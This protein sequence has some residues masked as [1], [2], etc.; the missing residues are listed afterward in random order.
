[1]HFKHDCR[2]ITPSHRRTNRTKQRLNRNTTLEALRQNPDVPVLIIGAG[3]N[4]IGVLRDLAL[5]GV[6]ALLI[7]KSDF[8]AG[9]SAASGRVAHG[10]LRYLENGEFRLVREALHERNRLLINAPHCVVP[11]PI[12]M[13]AYSWTKG[14]LHAARQFLHLKSRPGDRGAAILKLGMTLY[15]VYSGK[16]TL[17]AHRFINRKASL[18]NRPSMNPAITCTALYYDALILYPERLCLE[19]IFDAAESHPNAHALN[20]VSAVGIEGKSVLLRDEL[21]GEKFPIKPQVVVNATGAWID[22]TNRTMQVESAFIGGTKG[23]HLIVDHPELHRL[24]QG[25]MLFY[26]NNDARICIFYPLGHRVLIGTTDI[27][28]NDPDSVVCAEDE[29]EYLLQ[30]IC[31]VFP[32]IRLD[33]SHIVYTFSG[34][35]PLPKSSALTAGQ[36]S[37]DH[38]D[39]IIESGKGLPFRI[40]NLVGGKWTTYR[41]FAEQVTD[42]L[43]SELGEKRKADTRALRIGGGREFPTTDEQRRVWIK[44]IAEKTLLDEQRIDVLLTRYGTRAEII[45][46]YCAS[47]EDEPLDHHAD[48]T[49]REIRFM[50]EH[51]HVARLDDI[52]Q[53]RTMIAIL[54]ETTIPLLEEIAGIMATVFGWTEAQQ[55]D[56]IARVIRLFAE[57]HRTVLS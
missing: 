43:L 31:K 27:S 26:V 21:T 56:E 51:E 16:G 18:E 29:I 6:D 5:Q 10:G 47:D 50:V 42:R 34:I 17:P 8:C 32:D 41:A 39:Q 13:P 45:A 28:A 24:C 4:G 7:D 19:L 20:Y 2:K 52:L 25:Q 22:L 37:R 9:T 48:Y 54:G 57:K 55:R 30:S 23:S 35:R 46:A 38:S 36:I 3:V 40:H 49:R 33:R 14:L 12:A 11:L 15:D 53:R 1:M 44:R